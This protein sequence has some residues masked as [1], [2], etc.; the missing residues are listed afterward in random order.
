MRMEDLTQKLQNLKKRFSQKSKEDAVL[1]DQV[2]KLIPS[3]LLIKETSFTKNT[4]TLVATNKATAQ[5]LFL[6]R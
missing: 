1:R 4:V 3:A 5:E 6:I 2:K